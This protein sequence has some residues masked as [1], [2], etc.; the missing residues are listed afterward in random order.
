LD[1]VATDDLEISVILV[2][3]VVEQVDVFEKPLFMVL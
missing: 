1:V 3:F 2:L